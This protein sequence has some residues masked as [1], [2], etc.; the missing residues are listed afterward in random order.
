[1]I[2]IIN[3][4]YEDSLKQELCETSTTIGFT[5]IIR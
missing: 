3:C 5:A 4:P 2:K 1:M